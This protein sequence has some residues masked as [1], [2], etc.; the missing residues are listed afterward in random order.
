[1]KKQILAGMKRLK[2]TAHMMKL[3]AEDIPRKE[4]SWYG[5]ECEIFKRAMYLRCAVKDEI[6]R[7]A[8]FFPEH[9]RLGGRN[10][11]YEVF[12]SKKERQFITHDFLKEKW[13]EAKLD[14]LDWPSSSYHSHEKWISKADD[15]VIRIYLGGE[16]GGYEGLLDF[17]RKIRTEQL[18]RRHKKETDPWDKD[19]SQTAVLPKDWNRW[20]DKTGIRQNYLFYHY[21]KGGAKEGYCTF[22]GKE[23]PIAGHPRHNKEGRCVR[24]RHEV[25]FKAN[26][27]AGFFLTRDNYVYLIQ[28][29]R[30]GF[31][32]REFCAERT[33]RKGEYQTPRVPCREVRRVIYDQQLAPR[34]Y[35][36]GNYKQRKMRWIACSPCSPS[37]GGSEE[38]RIYGKTLPHLA[39]KELKQTG[40]VQWIYDKVTVDPEK[41]LAV[42]KEVP[43]LEQ[44][45]KA[46]LSRLTKE[47]MKE[48][49]NV[50]DRIQVPGAPGLIKALGLDS[51]GL[52]RLREQNGGHRFLAWLQYEKHTGRS[53]PDEVISWFCSENI[54]ASDL[55]FIRDKMSM[56]QIYNYICK[57]MPRF[58]KN[59]REVVNTWADYLSMAIR[60]HMNT[61]D[62]II[63]RARKLR[64]RHDELVQRC[65]EKAIDL[66]IEEISQKYPH[67]NGICQSLKEKYEYTD[68]DYAVIAPAG[69]E[70]V[71]MEGRFLHHCVG[72]S[73]R[74][75]DRIER[76]ESFVLFLRRA[77][78]PKTA[79]YTLE[80]EPDGT[81]RQKRT[82]FDR[83]EPD[84]E[85]A[86]K[87][88]AEWQKVIAARL[89]A[90]D[91]KLAKSSRVMRAEE[92]AQLKNDRVI[93]H[94]GHLAGRLLVDVLLADLMENTETLPAQEIPA[95]A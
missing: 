33:Y 40:L 84:I 69:V 75:W 43:Q 72:S 20:V 80:I 3:A 41:Y 22:C 14:L 34:A 15:A 47:C 6:L 9:M 18:E 65:Q 88:L 90:D 52:R 10:P 67:V 55:K 26:G 46:D 79:Y 16:R 36:W 53:I 62:E 28:R 77:G 39:K 35:Y 49:H 73:E 4:K 71:L 86:T 27:R 93:I 31:I 44:I 21:K 92:F 5:H 81:V 83:Q 76:R 25:T 85:E 57:Q 63:F 8:L 78:E 38:G 24:C 89:T 56:V 19:L 64:Q 87:F 30:D 32:V 70:D 23:V 29:C 42:L 66:Q 58:R 54:E 61:D 59:S 68:R 94:T 82:E 74:Y 60:L 37:W 50:R 48:C 13:R 11:S 51:Q 2:A 45:W 17:Q 95:A 91:R 7:V 12:V 1:M